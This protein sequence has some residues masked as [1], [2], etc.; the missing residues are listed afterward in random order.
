MA[1]IVQQ[2]LK[3]QFSIKK[4]TISFLKVQI[5]RNCT[6]P[7]VAFNVMK[8]EKLMPLLRT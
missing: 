8:Y 1:G 7:F 2:Q 5:I 4:S 3:S 6:E